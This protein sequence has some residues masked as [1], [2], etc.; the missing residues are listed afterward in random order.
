MAYYIPRNDVSDLLIGGPTPRA[1]SGLVTPD[2]SIMNSGLR[3]RPQPHV[4]GLGHTDNIEPHPGASSA[5]PDGVPG[6]ALPTA[7]MNGGGRGF[8]IHCSIVYSAQVRNDAKSQG[9][10]P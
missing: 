4:L 5:S 3:G 1:L 2:D 9:L 7:N 6:G 8:V 10:T